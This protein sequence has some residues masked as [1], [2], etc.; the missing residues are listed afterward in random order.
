[1]QLPFRIDVEILIE[2]MDGET[3]ADFTARARQTA[4]RRVRQALQTDNRLRLVSIK[5]ATKMKL[6][7]R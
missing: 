5:R 7:P 6:S 3:D 4:E 1:M 2:Q